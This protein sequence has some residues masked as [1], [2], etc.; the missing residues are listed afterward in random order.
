MQLAL[1]GDPMTAAD[2]HRWGLVNELTAPGEALDRAL[3]L[4]RRIARNGPLAV[5]TTERVIREAPS[6]PAGEVWE[7]QADLLGLV[8]GSQDAQE[9]AA[10]FA[11]KREPTWQ[12]R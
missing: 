4:A 10:A 12:G 2:A 5:R 3:D 9:G 8:F 6:W 1:T 11:E 7:R